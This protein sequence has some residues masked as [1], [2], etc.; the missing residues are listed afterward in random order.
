MDTLY[1]FGYK[2]PKRYFIQLLF[3]PLIATVF[4]RHFLVIDQHDFEMTKKN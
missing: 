3:L 1:S 2:L 4:F